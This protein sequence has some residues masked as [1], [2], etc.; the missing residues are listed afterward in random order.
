MLSQASNTLYSCWYTARRDEHTI[1]FRFPIGMVE[2]QG[3][4]KKP[5]HCYAF[6]SLIFQFW[7][8][9]PAQDQICSAYSIERFLTHF[10]IM[11]QAIF[12]NARSW[13]KIFNF[14]MVIHLMYA[15]ILQIFQNISIVNNLFF[16]GRGTFLLMRETAHML[17]LEGSKKCHL[18]S[19]KYGMSFKLHIKEV[20]RW[21]L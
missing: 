4:M 18:S 7:T 19:Q 10:L 6:F 15:L 8:I 16:Q 20:D 17:H 9:R 11:L 2:L 1:M 5:N 13:P 3:E 21:H 12:Q 14:T